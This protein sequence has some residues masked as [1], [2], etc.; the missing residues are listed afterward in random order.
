MVIVLMGVAGA[1]KTTVGR[2]LS[3]QLG[4]VFLDGD[5]VHPPENVAKM[6]RGTPL[7]EVDRRPWLEAL[8]QAI[9]VWVEQEVNAVLASSL[10]KQAHRI[11]V[12]A[13]NHTHV[14]LVYLQAARSLLQKRLTMRSDHFAGVA[15]LESQLALLEEPVDA[16]VL[17]ASHPPDELVHS[18][19]STLHL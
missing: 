6:A 1:G 8:R 14:R 17:D 3:Q 19:R 15:L 4:W 16:L 12:F 5:V 10:L 7:T 2:Q 9:A 13:R 11:A 18:I